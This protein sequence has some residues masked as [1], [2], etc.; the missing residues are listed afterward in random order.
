MDL[1][2]TNVIL[3]RKLE[4]AFE[5]VILNDRN[6]AYGI[7]VLKDTVTGD[8]DVH[9][10][11]EFLVEKYR[12]AKYETI[13]KR[14]YQIIPFLNY[15]FVESKKIKQL[16]N[17]ELSHGKEFLNG[18]TNVSRKTVE[19]F[20][21]TLREF[22]LFLIDHGC[23][24]KVRREDFYSGDST[25]K[26][27]NP[28][29]VTYSGNK[30]KR[31]LH[32]IPERLIDLF[33]TIAKREAYPIAF[34]IYLQIYG[35]LRVSEVVSLRYED[36]IPVG[37]NASFG[38]EA[39]LANNK[40]IRKDTKNYVST[41]K[42]ERYQYID[43]LDVSDSVEEGLEMYLEHVSTYKAKDNSG[44]LF[45]NVINGPYK[46]LPMTKKNYTRYFNRVKSAFCKE[47]MDP[48]NSI[49][50]RE[51]G[52]S[53]LTL[54]WST[55]IGRGIFTNMKARSS[56][57]AF[58]VQDARGDSGPDASAYYFEKAQIVENQQELLIKQ[59]DYIKSL[60][61]KK[62]Y[63]YDELLENNE[64][65]LIPMVS[66]NNKQDKLLQ[67]KANRKDVLDSIRDIIGDF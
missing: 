40:I 4:F 53:L 54:D 19:G 30:S 10:L 63:S 37:Y 60:L 34:G 3:I 11:T 25:N 35:G 5:S 43:P 50:D 44:A 67:N 55:H 24:N 28:F 6:R 46:G 41:V 64:Q 31:I 52:R 49:E 57:N 56:Q 38:F 17:F 32:D 13:K 18:L 39:T 12:N 66:L 26:K 62:E 42:K 14:A 36:L 22:Y 65:E 51:L 29:S 2:Q 27:E 47:L 7:I 1:D 8:Y 33:I 59:T 48:K 16:N 61:A 58:Q 9:Y 23:T 21:S 20:E 15:V 45:I